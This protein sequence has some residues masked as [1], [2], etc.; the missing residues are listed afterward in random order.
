MIGAGV[1]LVAGVA[2]GVA[3]VDDGNLKNSIVGALVAPYFVMLNGMAGAIIGGVTGLG[4]GLIF[5]METW[6]T[7]YPSRGGAPRF[8][9]GRVGAGLRIRV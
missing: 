3:F 9:P 1:G 8:P 7:V 2:Y 4:V 5:P 6:T